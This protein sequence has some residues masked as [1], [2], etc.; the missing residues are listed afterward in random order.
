MN[1]PTM[2][3]HRT[4]AGARRLAW[5]LAASL[6]VVGTVRAQTA[7]PAP[8]SPPESKDKKEEVVVLSPFVVD[9]STDE[10][11]RATSTLAGSRLNTPL[12]DVAASITV[13]TKEFMTDTAAVSINDVL[14][15]TAN[16]E[17]TR[18]FTA[19]TTS[20]GRPQDD[21]AIN[22][23]SSNRVRGLYAA[24]IT[25]DYLYTIGTWVGFDSY[26]LDQVT[27]NRGPNSALA[28]LGSPAGIVNYSPQYASLG[29]NHNE[30][31]LRFGSYDDQRYT[32][33]SNIVVK[34][35][36]LAVRVAAAYSDKGFKQQPAFNEDTRLYGAVT[37]KPWS[38][39]TIR[40]TYENVGIKANNPN[41][42]TPEDD[43]TQWVALGKPSY[44]QNSA[45]PVSSL[46]W[47]DGN[48]PT[49]R[50]N[51]GGPI[52]NS[53]NTNLGYYF[54]QQNV[55]NVGI[56][57]PVRMSSNQ[58]LSLDTVNTSPSLADLDYEAFNISLD[59]EITKDLFLNLA[60]V[61]ETIENERL[62]LFRTEYSNYLV[63][64]NVRTP[65]GSPNPHY[66]ETYMQ[67][68]GL[69]N[70]QTD[71]NSNDVFRATLA[72]NLDLTKYNKWFGHYRFTG[73]YENRETETEH[74]QYNA[75]SN[76]GSTKDLEIGY[77]YYL[78]GSAT[79][80]ATTVSKQPGLVSNV[81]NY[82]VG[83]GFDKLNA[84][85]ALKS[86]NLSL[87]KL[88]SLA[89]VGQ[90]YLWDDKIV[91]LYGIRKDTN[92]VGYSSS[93]DGGT[94]IVPPAS[95]NYGPLSEVSKTTASY[96]IVVHPLKWLSVYYNHAENFIP[97]AGSI[98]LLGNPTATPTGEGKDYG[99]S[100][101]LFEGKLNAKLNWFELT[102]SNGTAGNPAN[103]P[104]AQWNLTFMDLVVMPEAAAKI[105]VPYQKGVADGIIVGDPRLANAYTS[106]NVSE[107]LEFELTY[108]VTKNWRIMA[109]V[110]K[111]EAKQSNIAPA[112]TT[113]IEERIAYWKS[114]NLWN[115][116]LARGGSAWGLNQTGEEHFNQFLL[117]SY[118][119]YKSVDNKPSQQL[120]KWHASGLTNYQFSEGTLKGLNIGAGVRYIE[121]PVIGN[122][123]ILDSSGAVVALDLDNPYY[124]DGFV[125]IDAW[126][127]YKTE[128]TL[129]GD[130]RKVSFQLNARDLQESGG[131][132][133]IG[134]NSDGTQS[135]FSIVQPRTFY[136]TTTF[137]F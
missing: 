51:N 75:R 85:Y 55:N 77:R 58:Y 91:G 17:G 52:E 15:Y 127:G 10:G 16:T 104:L 38:K 130:K 61:H 120:S 96:G 9:S 74:M 107:G 76:S 18:D 19:S 59:Q 22:S 79:T 71:D 45:T 97:N 39:T 7:A 136:L 112:L 117:G 23:N 88:E 108:N 102:A 106:D 111:Q 5:T 94:G 132:R 57:T 60:Y 93:V 36:V 56:W 82:L 116:D 3:T 29:R 32:F 27:I 41:T 92:K 47:Q 14:A 99:F 31:S 20:L 113:L 78:G 100:V 121:K 95:R 42:L 21:V 34:P 89:A 33:N 84:Y 68:R 124:G 70:K 66:G 101:D 12:R 87:T 123:A 109:S 48:L 4:L 37:Y 49:V 11:Y 40:A 131:F 67:Y 54:N 69:D 118:V 2:Q 8:D 50:F 114:A 46:L 135:V 44:D 24:D 13:V 86:D 105:G 65:W 122:P 110:S 90:A 62:D 133:P 6:A 119:G 83:G 25:R 26:N 35:E 63:D 126:I 98:D 81:D 28:G 1:T 73:F 103:F 80:M 137:E 43:V 72:Y 129:F 125:S 134:A 30:V 64:V 128:F 53:I 115:N